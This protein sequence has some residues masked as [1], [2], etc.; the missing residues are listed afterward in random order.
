MFM[1]NDEQRE[2]QEVARRFAQQELAPHAQEWDERGAFP[3]DLFPKLA[4]LAPGRD[5]GARGGRRRK[6]WPS[7]DRRRP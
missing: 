3:G 7:A 4:D 2:I 5:A 1:L 6:P